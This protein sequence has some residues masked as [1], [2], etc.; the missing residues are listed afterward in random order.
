[1]TAILTE[2][3]ATVDACC[4]HCGSLVAV[5]IRHRLRG[6]PDLAVAVVCSDCTAIMD[7]G[8]YADR[9]GDDDKA[10]LR[11]VA[12]RVGCITRAA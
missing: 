9:I 11:R 12:H 2:S 1:M 6:V 5:S 3:A 10:E 4:R 8:R 7:A